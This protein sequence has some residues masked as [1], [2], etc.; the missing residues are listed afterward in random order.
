M[1]TQVS[2]T[3]RQRIARQCAPDIL[4]G[5]T[6]QRDADSKPSSMLCAALVA[7][8]IRS[9]TCAKE[10][11][12]MHFPAPHRHSAHRLVR[13]DSSKSARMLFGRGKHVLHNASTT[14]SWLPRARQVLSLN[15]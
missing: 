8:R 9:M 14:C 2:T 11:M 3:R 12:T 7:A 10:L 4:E 1:D 13:A 15:P 5:K 6:A